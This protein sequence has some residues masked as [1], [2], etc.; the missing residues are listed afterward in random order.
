[1][2]LFP[3]LTT[4]NALRL[5]GLNSSSCEQQSDA[6]HRRS[7]DLPMTWYLLV[8]ITAVSSQG[9][10]DVV[11]RAWELYYCTIRSSRTPLRHGRF[12]SSCNLP[13]CRAQGIARITLTFPCS[14]HLLVR[15]TGDRAALSDETNGVQAQFMSGVQEYVISPE[16]ASDIYGQSFAKHSIH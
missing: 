8:R 15:C 3:L 7:W 6:R 14:L 2:E 1:M 9:T 4:F 12:L 13:L 5:I 11:E 10:F 16:L